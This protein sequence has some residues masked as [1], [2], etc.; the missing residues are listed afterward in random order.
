MFQLKKRR[1]ICSSSL[2]FL[3][4]G[5]QWIGWCL[6]HWWRWIFLTPSKNLHVYLPRSSLPDTPRKNVL[7]AIWVSLHLVTLTHKITHRKTIYRKFYTA[8]WDSQKAFIDCC[9]NFECVA[10]L[11]GQLTN[12][13]SSGMNVGWYFHLSEYVRSETIKIRR[14][15]TLSSSMICNFFPELGNSF[16]VLEEYFL[17]FLCYS[18]C[19]GIDKTYC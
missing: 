7:P 18:P 1:R 3:E 11:W 19:N 15:F 8:K 2:C 4:E 5:S 13:W 14:N 9:W 16:W 6:P 17:N 10:N 12:R